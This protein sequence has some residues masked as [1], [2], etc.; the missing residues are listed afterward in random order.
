M[1]NRLFT[2]NGNG[3]AQLWHVAIDAVHGHWIG[4]TGAGSYE[5][6]WDRSPKANEVL[7]NAHGLYVETLTE[8]GIVGLGLLVALLAIPLVAGLRARRVVLMP[9]LIGAYVTFV[10]HN[11]IDWDWQLSGLTL[12]GLFI[13]CALLV[14]RRDG[15]ERS[16]TI[17]AR[18]AAGGAATVVAAIALVGALGNGA[19]AHAQ[20]AN[21]AKHYPA[22][23][24]DASTARTWMP[25]SDE[26]LKARGTAQ[27]EQGQIAAA[28]RTFR[29]ATSLDPGDWQAW[30]DLAASVQG[31][32]RAQA[33]ARARAL[34][35]NSPEIVTFL[36]E[37]RH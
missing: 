34:Y 30:L 10:L 37:S 12:A 18:A 16:L 35:P 24:K 21:D 9:P 8:L 7:R 19:L 29:K 31:R 33:V 4:G 3:R 28:Q 17:P 22:A 36:E 15:E 6:D 13:G 23:A 20:A 5:R 1:T 26:P 14:S 11:A 2:L 25:W 32:A 27:L